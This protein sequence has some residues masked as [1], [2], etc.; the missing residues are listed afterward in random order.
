MPIPVDE[1]GLTA[2]NA[3]E[4]FLILK[5]NRFAHAAMHG[6]DPQNGRRQHS[7]TY[8]YGPSGVGKS[9]LVRQFLRELRRRE[10]AIRLAHVTASQFAADFS[11]AAVAKSTDVFRRR[12]RE[13]DLLVC[14]DLGALENRTESQQQLLL[15][16][17]HV[18][19]EGGRCLFTCR[20]S[21]GGLSNVLPRLLNRCRSGVSASIGLPGRSS[22]VALI[23][24]FARARQIP[25]SDD[26]AKLLATDLPVSPRELLATVIQ[27]D[28]CARLEGCAFDKQ[29]AL[30]HLESEVK[31]TPI[32]L[33]QI[34]RATAREF[35]VAMSKI[36]G[37]ERFHGHVV[38]RHC[39]MYLARELTGKPLQKLAEYFGRSNHSTVSYA[40]REIRTKMLDDAALR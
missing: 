15:A 35:G 19:A 10:T 39:A 21:P 18:L 36:R 4:V 27:I 16:M 28:A 37:R 17:D 23:N 33:S 22:R 12:Y 1:N 24:H 8:L 2:R 26:V 6:L 5:E 20:T 3:T 32:T 14:E 31:P 38:P 30:R 13:L 11:E 7:L 40:C 29:L 25:I 9:H 34:T